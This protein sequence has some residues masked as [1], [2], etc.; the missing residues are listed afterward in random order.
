MLGPWRIHAKFQE[1]LK[2][3]VRV[4]L[5][6]EPAKVNFHAKAL[7]KVYALNL[8]P[9]KEL[10]EPMYSPIGRPAVN[11]PE[12]FRAMVLAVHYQISVTKLV[13]WLRSDEV[14]AIACG[15]EPDELPGVG[16]FYDLFNRLWLAEVPYKVLR[17]PLQ[18]KKKELKANEK[19]PP[20]NPETVDDL[21]RQILN[22]K[23]SGSGL[24]RLLQDILAEC[25][26]RPSAELNL[27][28][29]TFHLTFAGDG[30]PLATGGN[31]R[32]KKVCDCKQK[33]IY[34]C[35]CHRYYT[36]ANANWGWDSYH[37]CWFYGHTL[38]CLN[39]ANSSSDLP[40]M[41]SLRQASCHDS[42]T[43][44]M[45]FD[46]L[47]SVLPEFGFV[48]VLLDSAHDAYSIYRLLNE[49]E[50]EPFIDLNP[51]TKKEG[52]NDDMATIDP[53]G[54][55]VCKA[56]LKMVFWGIDQRRYRLK[57]RC[58]KYKNPNDCEFKEQCSSSSYGKVKYTRPE[59]DLR[60]FTKTP[61]GTKAWKKIY[62]RRSSAERSLKR[63]LVDYLI[64]KL[65]ARS[66]KQW[67]W[68]ATLAAIN[69]HLDAQ[70]KATACSLIKELPL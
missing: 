2:E 25:A 15:F 20:D 50:I 6:G 31:A 30:A 32:G 45:A 3:K 58:P 1:Q 55:P 57:W 28:G 34:R 53:K 8:D 64:E 19:L 46:Q 69:V 38:Y 54:I 48:K 14:L 36:D 27:L 62:A 49:K 26:V 61:R 68:W 67:F 5:V 33:G 11:Q 4:L 44:V 7:E 23:S 63:M 60:L 59:K 9:L 47:G 66:D 56:E 18:K 21:V 10:V 42:I 39:A 51:R 29:D 12:I 65:R 13:Q 41:L 37:R 35:S 52:K 24:E 70:V 43:F 17:P 40:L 16:N 22:G